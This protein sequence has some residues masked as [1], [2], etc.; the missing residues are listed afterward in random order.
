MRNR[1]ILWL[2][3]F[4]LAGGTL[5]A[6][7]TRIPAKGYA[8]FSKEGSFQPY[9]FTRHAV[10]EEDILLDLLYC[11]I[12]HTDLHF[13]R[14]DWGEEPYPM[15]PGHEMVGKVVRVGKKVKKFQVGD[16]AAVGCMVNSCGHCGMCQRGEEQYCETPGGRILSYAVPDTFHGNE[17]T[18]GG[19]ANNMVVSEKFAVKVPQDAPMEKIGPLMCAGITTYSPLK[20]TRVKKGDKV[21]VA[22]FGGLGHMAVQYAVAFGA[23]VTVF[24]VNESKRQDALAMGATKFVNVRN[25]EECQGLEHTFRVILSTIPAKYDPIFYVNMLQT[26][27]ELVIVGLPATENTPMLNTAALVIL[28]RRHVCGSQ[29]GGIAESQEM[30]DFSI[31]HGIYPHVEVIPVW[32]IDEAFEHLQN[33]TAKYRYVIDLKTLDQT[34]PKK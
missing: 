2:L 32:K 31:K 19:Y 7:E 23:E 5:W 22:G 11:G 25:P 18:C 1:N 13:V 21:G 27:G 34:P 6:E 3:V 28:G 12:C 9:T 15:V 14:G 24:D 8:V 10:G 20:F 17:I 16:Y 29:I 33:G 30:M 4:L 26:D